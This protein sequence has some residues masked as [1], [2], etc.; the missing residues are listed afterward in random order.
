MNKKWLTKQKLIQKLLQNRTIQTIRTKLIRYKNWLKVKNN[1]NQITKLPKQDKN[2]LLKVEYPAKCGGN[3]DNYYHFIV[4]LLLPFDLI[5]SKKIDN[6]FFFIEDNSPF[7][8]IMIQ[9]YP[10]NINVIKNINNLDSYKILPLQGMSPL[11]VIVTRKQVEYFRKNIFSKLN[12]DINKKNNKIL[13]IERLSPSQN[14]ITKNTG[15]TRRSII[16]HQELKSTIS[17][18]VKDSFEFHNLELENMTFKE[19][20]NYFNEADLIIAQHGAGLVNCIWMKETTKVIELSHKYEG[21]FRTLSKI[22]NLDYYI[23]FTNSPH[24]TIDLTDFK[25]WLISKNLHKYFNI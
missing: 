7:I 5:F 17:S 13:L 15:A 1:Q 8:K 23:Y 9:L 2:L 25:N 16:N 19:Q 4:D 18:M 22:K 3:L 20:I 24:A 10:E 6:N 21:H 12:I 14:A 11:G